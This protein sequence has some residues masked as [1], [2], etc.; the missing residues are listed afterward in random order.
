MCVEFR[1]IKTFDAITSY[2]RC[3]HIITEYIWDF[4]D[5][6]KITTPNAKI[7]HEYN[8]R[9]QYF[10]TLTIKTNCTPP[11]TCTI[12]RAFRIERKDW[13]IFK[14]LIQPVFSLLKVKLEVGFSVASKETTP[15][16][17]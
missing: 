6:I 16:P 3:E 7:D 8:K 11:Q 4:H 12:T 14:K 10:T 2:T 9:A 15:P 5:G 1:Y 13:W 17:T